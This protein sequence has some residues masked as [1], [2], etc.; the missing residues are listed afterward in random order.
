MKRAKTLRRKLKRAGVTAVAVPATST[1]P[2][3]GAVAQAVRDRPQTLVAAGGALEGRRFYE[4]GGR[5]C[6][7]I[8]RPAMV[9]LRGGSTVMPQLV[10]VL[11]QTSVRLGSGATDAPATAGISFGHAVADPGVAE[12]AVLAACIRAPSP[13]SLL[14][15]PEAI[16]ARAAMRLWLMRGQN[17]NSAEETQATAGPRPD[18]VDRLHIPALPGVSPDAHPMTRLPYMGMDTGF[19]RLSWHCTERASAFPVDR[20]R[21]RSAT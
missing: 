18:P 3:G 1:D 4:D 17:R 19:R 16:R 14:A 9:D 8:A 15:V 10:R 12:A 11:Y 2:R 13:I 6:R 7:A 20:G 21:S 5:D